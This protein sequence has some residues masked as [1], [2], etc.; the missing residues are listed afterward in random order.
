MAALARDMR[1][2]VMLPEARKTRAR[3]N[4]ILLLGSRWSAKHC[5][6]PKQT[7]RPHR[8]SDAPLHH[9][10]GGS[11]RGWAEERI[12]ALRLRASAN[13]GVDR[14]YVKIGFREDEEDIDRSGRGL[15]V[16]LVQ[17]IVDLWPAEPIR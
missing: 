6:V 15:M 9:E 12:K 7:R 17:G 10:H 1:L 16:N 2:P 5:H 14:V 4:H 13:D 3:S 8:R 11:K